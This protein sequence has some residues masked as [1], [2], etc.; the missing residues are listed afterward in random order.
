MT[1]LGE[2]ESLSPENSP[3]D[4]PTTY[5]FGLRNS[6]EVIS[7]YVPQWMR[8]SYTNSEFVGMADY[9]SE[10]IYDLLG[11][12]SESLSTSR[13][14]DGSHHPLHECFMVEVSDGHVS[15]ANGTEGDLREVPAPVPV[16]RMVAPRLS[17][18][19]ASAPP[20]HGRLRLEQLQA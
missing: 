3:R 17:A 14:R 10:S 11:M 12:G 7:S 2:G 16:D 20:Q 1:Q 19:V 9:I 15:S 8:P 6:A 5:P 4:V 13:S 18:L